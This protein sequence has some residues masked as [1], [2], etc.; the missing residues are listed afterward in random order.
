LAHT[1]APRTSLPFGGAAA[2]SARIT[3]VGVEQRD[4]RVEIT[5]AQGSEEGVDGHAAD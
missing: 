1:R 5:V 4:Q 2:Q 3:K